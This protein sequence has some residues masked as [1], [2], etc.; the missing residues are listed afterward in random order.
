MKRPAQSRPLILRC[1]S[2]SVACAVAPM[3]LRPGLVAS[4]LQL[5][6]EARGDRVAGV[7]RQQAWLLVAEGPGVDEEPDSVRTLDEVGRRQRAAA[8]LAR[9][10]RAGDGNRA[11]DVALPGADAV[12]VRLDLAQP[13]VGDEEAE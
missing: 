6:E 4:L 5:E 9:R 12:G 7:V 11:D 1:A 8:R 13:G 2:A 10:G 3:A